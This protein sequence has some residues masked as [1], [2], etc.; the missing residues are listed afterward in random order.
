M[1][2][3][4]PICLSLEDKP[5]VVVGGGGVAYRK[6]KSLLEAGARVTVVSPRFCE[7][8]RKLSGVKRVERPFQEGD[9]AGAC[10][11]YA[12]TDDPAVNSTVAAAARKAGA[13]V[14]VV[15]TPEECDFIVPSTLRR[16]PLTISVS[17]GG[18]APALA[19]RLR[20]KLEELFPQAYDAFVALLAEVRREALANVADHAVREAALRRL[21]DE[22]TWQLF[23]TAGP[24]AVRA[25]AKRLLAGEAE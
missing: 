3:Y 13:L 19:Q 7:E 15:D 23:A 9:V 10:L 2:R 6:A 20:L 8:L 5:C 22:T 16:G 21:A 1:A 12:A 25:L 17:T 14:N 4:Y 24:E 11:V 18:A